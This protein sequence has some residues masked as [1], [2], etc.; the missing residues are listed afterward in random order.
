MSPLAQ[1][2]LLTLSGVESV[3]KEGRYWLL[4]SQD[5]DQTLRQL[6]LK[7]EHIHDL[8]ITKQSLATIFS[9]MIQPEES[10]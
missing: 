6:S 7:I 1:A 8:T 2:E 9:D 4:T 5:S 10:K 3:T